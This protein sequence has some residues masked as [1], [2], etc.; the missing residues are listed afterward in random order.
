[1]LGLAFTLVDFKCS[2]LGEMGEVNKDQNV[3]LD[4]GA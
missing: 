2:G 4:D 1:M 3:K